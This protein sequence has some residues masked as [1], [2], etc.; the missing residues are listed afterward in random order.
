MHRRFQNTDLYSR[1]VWSAELEPE[2]DW[3]R[4]GTLV[5]VKPPLHRRAVLWKHVGE[6][7]SADHLTPVGRKDFSHTKVDIDSIPVFIYD[8]NSLKM[9]HV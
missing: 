1:S 7:S 4:G 9:L 3:L 2:I 6:A 8:P 5:L